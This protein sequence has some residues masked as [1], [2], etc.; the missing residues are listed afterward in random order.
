MQKSYAESTLRKKY[1]ETA[2]DHSLIDLVKD[3]LNACAF[4]YYILEIDEFWK[5]IQKRSVITKEQFDTLLP[6]LRR[7]DSLE[8]VIIEEADLY[9]DGAETLLLVLKKFLYVPNKDCDL[10][11][12]ARHLDDLGGYDG[13]PPV[14]VDWDRV[15]ALDRARA[16]KRLFVPDNLLDYATEGY[17]EETGEAIALRDFIEE[18]IVPPEDA[19]PDFPFS[20]ADAGMEIVLWV[21]KDV[22]S[23]P[24]GAIQDVLEKLQMIR[25]FPESESD[26]TIFVQLF[27]DLS[28]NTRMPMNK[29]FTPNE[30]HKHANIG[31]P[32]SIQFGPGIKNAIRSGD[33]NADEL[34]Q[35]I[36]AQS[37]WPTG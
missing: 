10:K 28:N 5:I 1:R 15:I 30:L 20:A 37:D 33:L 9:S 14:I 22:T 34:R 8:C 7:D 27:M 3:Y 4:F 31:M 13:P 12:Y 24:T 25:F 17:Y 35:A 29:G 19:S 32:T 26:I 2:I 18:R 6:I 21:I 11:E 36:F 23:H 16:G